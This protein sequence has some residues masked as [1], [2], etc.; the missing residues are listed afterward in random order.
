MLQ[1]T[2]DSFRDIIAKLDAILAP[3]ILGNVDSGQ[4]YRNLN[5]ILTRSAR[6]AFL[7]FAQPG[8][9]RFDFSA[10]EGILVVFPAFVQTVDDRG[11]VLRPQRVLM[12]KEIASAQV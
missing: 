12:E 10:R 1:D 11:Q 8:T 6:L 5:M 9:F 3:F 4:R 7:L 2:P